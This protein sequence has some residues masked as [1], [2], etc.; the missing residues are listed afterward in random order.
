MKKTILYISDTEKDIVKY[1]ESFQRYLEGHEIL[2]S[3]DK[4]I[5]F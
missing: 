5:E 3:L 1:L 2:F 4:K